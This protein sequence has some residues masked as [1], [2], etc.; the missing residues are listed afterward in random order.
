[1]ATVAELLERN[2]AYAP[3]HV[4]LPYIS[5]AMAAGQVLATTA[6]ITCADPRCTP[7]AFLDLK[8]PGAI[9]LRSAGG[10]VKPVLNSLLYIDGLLQLSELMVIHHTDCGATKM[11]DEQARGALKQ[12]VP[13]YNEMDSLE[14][15]TFKPE[16]LANSV[17]DDVKFVKQ[18]PLVRKTLADGSVGFTYDIKTGKLTPVEV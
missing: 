17:K 5:E 1:M 16:D 4:A 10:R 6:I 7:E 15:N 2:K 13:D 3:N 11:T 14:F 9:V 18:H 12:R 8:G